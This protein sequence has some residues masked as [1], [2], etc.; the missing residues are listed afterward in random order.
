MTLVVRPELIR[1]DEDNREIVIAVAWFP[2][3]RAIRPIAA[4]EL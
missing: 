1:W 4:W 2:G 3:Q